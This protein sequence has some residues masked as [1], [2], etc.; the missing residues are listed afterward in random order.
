[1]FDKEDVDLDLA[2][3]MAQL[4]LDKFSSLPKQGKPLPGQWTVLSGVILQSSSEVS[5]ISLATGTKSLS[6]STRRNNPPGTLVHDSHAEVLAR[7]AAVRWIM[8]LV[9]AG[10]QGRVFSKSQDGSYDVKDDVSFHMF[11]S[12]PPCGDASIFP[13]QSGEERSDTIGKPV[14]INETAV[15][16][17]TEDTVE[18]AKKKAKIDVNRTGAKCVE[19]GEQDKKSDGAG[20]HAVGQ[21]RTKPGRGDRTLSLSCSDKM[22]KW[23]VVGFQGALCS[24][25]IKKPIFFKTLVIASGYFDKECLERGLFRR[26]EHGDIHQ[27]NIVQSKS[28]FSFEKKLG[29]VPSP[30]S[31]LWWE[32]MDGKPESY[33]EGLKQGW[34]RKKLENPKSW[35]AVSQ[36]K[37]AQQFSSILME[38]VGESDKKELHSYFEM[39]QMAREYSEKW[40]ACK[41]YLKSWPS[42][43]FRNFCV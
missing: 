2:E 25:F 42:K 13:I 35:A 38:N 31:I 6:G 9:K 34:S 5:V 40:T 36:R 23:N 37:I 21:I 12:H 20:Y 24:V 33:V 14:P 1:M 30:D 39:K 16:V 11:S 19:N 28:R 41:I 8:Q 32:L 22:L 26:Y 15:T 3:K 29:S 4:C 10:N 17:D 43:E 7:R 18:P 27:I